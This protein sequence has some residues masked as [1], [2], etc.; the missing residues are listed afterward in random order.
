MQDNED[1]HSIT[2]I[3]QKFKEVPGFKLKTMSVILSEE[4]EN[5]SNII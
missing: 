3:N 1:R 5:P 2:Q 4:N